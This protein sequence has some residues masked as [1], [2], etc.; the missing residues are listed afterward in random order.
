MFLMLTCSCVILGMQR[1]PHLQ[2]KPMQAAQIQG[3]YFVMWGEDDAMMPPAFAER[4]F[5]VNANVDSSTYDGSVSFLRHPI[6]VIH[7]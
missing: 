3:M 1:C 5:Q 2:C 4:L 7:M 6:H